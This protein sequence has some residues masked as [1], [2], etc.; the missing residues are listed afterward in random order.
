MQVFLLRP[1]ILASV[2]FAVSILSA[3]S[4]LGDQDLPRENLPKS[5]KSDAELTDV[6]FLNA[7]LGW[8]VGAQGV[9]VRTSDGGRTWSEI[10]EVAGVTA[11]DMSLDEK[12]RLMRSGLETR[13]TGIANG[14][15]I[16]QPMRCRFESVF[17][18]DEQHGWVAGGY[19]V[20]YVGRSRAVVM[21]TRDGGLTWNAV[22]N[23]VAPRFNRIHFSDPA[24]GW[25]IGKTGNLFP[26]GIYYTS[27]GGQTWS[28]QSSEKT[29][30]WI[31]AEQTGSGFVT[32][33]YA[34]QLGIIYGHDY[35][36]SVVLQGNGARISRVRMLDSKTGWAVGEN[37]TLLQTDNGGLSWSPIE[38]PEIANLASNFD[39]NTIAVAGTTIWLAGNPGTFLFSIDRT[40]GKS[41]AF[42]TPNNMR[43]NKVH[44]FD[45]QTGWAVGA[46]GVIVAT[47]DGGQTWKVQRSGTQRTAILCVASN[48]QSLPFEVLA[49]YATEE[50]NLCGSMILSGSAAQNQ[51]A[52]QATERL[53]STTMVYVDVQQP[54]NVDAER[55]RN[56]VLEKMVREIRTLQPNVIVCNSGH[57]FSSGRDVPTVNPVTLIQDAIRLASDGNSY[58]GQIAGSLLKP[59]QVDRLAI[60]DPTGD[61]SIDPQRLLPRTGALI[62]DQISLSRALIGQSV[63]SDQP[64]TYRV[65]HFTN[66]DRMKAGDL[67]SGL[68]P[69]KLVPPRDD[70]GVKR[71]NLNMIQQANAKHEKFEQFVRF[72]ANTPQDL[73]VWR[74]QI[75]SFA[76]RM[77]QDVAGVWLMQLAERYLAVGKIELAASAA[78]LLVTRWS[79]HA[80]APACLTW[81][82]Q[83]YGSEE[84][85]QIE[86]LK[87]VKNGQLQ[88][89]GQLSKAQQV[90]SDFLTAPQTIQGDGNAHLVWTPTQAM[91]EKQSVNGFV[92]DVALVSGEQI[93][94]PEIPALFDQRLQLA[95]QFLAQ[96]SQRDPE[97]AAGPQYQMLEAQLSRRLG[98]ILSNEGRF[99][100][101]ILQRDFDGAGISLGAQR[102]LG[103]SGR[104]PTNSEP[105]ALFSC[106]ETDQRPKLDGLLNDSCW[107]SALASGNVATPSVQ[108]PGGGKNPDT[109]L[110]MF[111]YDEEFLYAGVRCQKIEGQYYNTR[112]QARPRD[113]DL[114][115]RDRVELAFDVDRDYRSANRFVIDHRGWV[116]ESC[117]GSLGW[118]PDW[119]VS[120][121]DDETTWT[122]EIA[123]PLAQMI[124][125][126]IE[127]GSTWAFQAA[128]RAYYPNNLWNDRETNVT[129]VDH[130]AR[131]GIQIGLESRPS[132]F[133]L[134]RFQAIPTESNEK[135]V[136]TKIE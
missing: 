105:L 76:M 24:N 9:I 92:P 23:L 62:E 58:P 101:L 6:F 4:G 134:I 27:D 115:H 51:A 95:S 64:S 108:L 45:E 79:D 104:L 20:P 50:N 100:S 66:R 29:H 113:A 117:T 25:A 47:L 90:Q 94:T 86:F 56:Q 109:D 98:G 128:R 74:Q 5:W 31:D 46:A 15:S 119:Y 12:I 71:G 116:Q 82:A 37:G 97:L 61:I 91:L 121:S 124:P 35:E 114:T 83:Y 32:V 99:K 34:G 130:A 53:G 131:Q 102:E 49:K 73:V 39:L 59:W 57:S 38:M 28:S 112:P 80:F 36:Q 78:T 18:V 68:D 21:R 81:L 126:R 107:Q 19:E 22:K 136:P 17:F 127:P 106:R 44:F 103:L 135:S 122:V 7:N 26:S 87:R 11:G 60:L 16:Q 110:V 48:D 93:E 85:A 2:L 75:Q 54:L 123:I 42:R 96:I 1:L 3:G 14:S 33:S 120:Q 118:N 72:E 129:E 67:L 125:A 132:D 40:T 88:R 55:H 52:T 63:L 65:T 10:S 77:E 70:I 41:S 30:S 84:F 8:A 89:N 111:A 43:I 133:E 13:S 69:R